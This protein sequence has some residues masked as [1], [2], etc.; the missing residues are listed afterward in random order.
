MDCCFGSVFI[1]EINLTFFMEHFKCSSLLHFPSPS[2][3]ASG[4]YFI[5]PSD[6]KPRH[7]LL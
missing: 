5:L 2:K 3:L 7:V 6:K 1:V 4:F